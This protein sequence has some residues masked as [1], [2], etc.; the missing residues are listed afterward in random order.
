MPELP[1][2]E[3]VVRDL[4]SLLPGRIIQRAQLLRPGLAQASTRQGFAQSLRGAR[5]EEVARRGK[6]IILRLDNGRALITHLRMTGRFLV[7]E[8]HLAYPDHTHAIFWLDDGKKLLFTDQRHFG[9][10]MIV[11]IAKLLEA[12]P[13]RRLAPEPFDGDF[14][15]EYLYGVLARSRRQIKTLLLDQTRVTGLGNIYAAEALHRARINPR[16]AAHRISPRRASRLR[17]EIVAVLAS[18]IES[19]NLVE[20]DS[21]EPSTRYSEGSWEEGWRVYDR[22]GQP[23]PDCATPVKRFVQGARSTY[24]CPRCQRR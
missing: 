8:S 7:V 10:M 21:R 12:A 6:H 9:M 24:Y 5:I 20:T 13:L 14:T 22:E 2:V 3:M 23:C 19:G 4:R 17:H 16:V 18:A 15:D 11:P 1:E